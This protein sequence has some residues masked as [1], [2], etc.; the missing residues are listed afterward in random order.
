M[1]TQP[2]LTPPPPPSPPVNGPLRKRHRGIRRT[3]PRNLVLRPPNT[4]TPRIHPRRPRLPL[5]AP[6]RPTRHPASRHRTRAREETSGMGTR[7]S[8][9]DRA[10]A[11]A[12][13]QSGSTGAARSVSGASAADGGVEAATAK[14]E[15]GDDGGGAAEG[16]GVASGVYDMRRVVSS[17]SDGRLCMRLIP[18]RRQENIPALPVIACKLHRVGVVPLGKLYHVQDAPGRCVRQGRRSLGRGVWRERAAVEW[19]G[20]LKEVQKGV[21]R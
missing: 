8:G 1:S 4:A 14:G 18:R 13:A 15:G 2:P 6:V 17:Q 5:P 12:A 11:W 10:R 9:V 7:R 21:G 3:H 19:S 16:G 20:G